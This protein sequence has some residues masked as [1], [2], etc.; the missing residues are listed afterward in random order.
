MDLNAD[1]ILHYLRHAFGG[2]E[3]VLERVDDDTVNARPADW[4]TNSIAGLVVH[5]CELTP[6][7]FMTP[8]LGRESERDRD[9]EFEATATVEE[10]QARI[11]QTVDRLAP[12]VEEFVAGPTALDHEYRAFLPGGDRSDSALV[13]HVLEE[14]FQH[15]GHMEVTA[16]AL[17]GNYERG[18]RSRST[19]VDST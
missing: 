19:G 8:G 5:C 6:S 11:S 7:W 10:L 17:A 13:I 15:L 4:G 12:L 16:D 3:G 1:T 9:A 14:L 18:G 2:M